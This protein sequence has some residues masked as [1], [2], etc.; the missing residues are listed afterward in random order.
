MQHHTCYSSC[1][2][3]VLCKYFS[4]NQQHLSTL[5]NMSC[6]TACAAVHIMCRVSRIVLARHTALSL[7]IISLTSRDEHARSCSL[8]TESAGRWAPINPSSLCSSSYLSLLTPCCVPCLL[9]CG[10]CM[11]AAWS[12]VCA[13]AQHFQYQHAQPVELRMGSRAVCAGV[14]LH[15]QAYVVVANRNM[16]AG[17]MHACCL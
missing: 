2:L 1:R 16:S 11:Y 3:Q 10:L 7:R 9:V 5:S 13:R 15:L 6:V 12:A 14:C 17:T 4:T 8:I